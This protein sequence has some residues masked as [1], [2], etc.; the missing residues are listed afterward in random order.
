MMFGC[1]MLLLLAAL[2]HG[3]LIAGAE[4]APLYFELPP[5]LF[6]PLNARPPPV[7]T[8]EAP[9]DQPFRV[10]VV[11]AGSVRSFAFVEKS[12]RR[13]LIEPWEKHLHF[14]GHVVGLQNCPIARMGLELLE[15]LCTSLEVVYTNTPVLSRDEV[16]AGIPKHYSDFFSFIKIMDTQFAGM[17]RGNYFDMHI[18]RHRAYSL[19]KTYASAKGFQWDLVMFI[20]L[21][22]AF[23]EPKLD[24]YYWFKT[25]REYNQTNRGRAIMIPN[26]CNFGGVCDRLAAGMPSEMD[27]YFKENFPFEVLHWSLIEVPDSNPLHHPKNEM[28]INANSEHLLELWFLMNNITQMFFYHPKQVAFVTLRSNHASAYCSLTRDDYIMRYPKPEF[29]FDPDK[30]MANPQLVRGAADFDLV[31]DAVQRCGHKMAALNSSQIC[32]HP[33]CQCGEWGRRRRYLR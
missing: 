2:R 15:K 14:F 5:S 13:Y 8:M 6:Q 11:T 21:D 12:W 3:V 10:A 22:T 16:V 4:K 30:C 17:N 29:V 7:I 9:T 28:K 31:A 32:L 18:R 24:L 1:A 26:E 19:A 20:R 23:Y 33:G 25:I 27:L